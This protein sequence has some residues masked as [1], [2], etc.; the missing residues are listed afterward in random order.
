MSRC[1]P[2]YR[3]FCKVFDRCSGK[4]YLPNRLRLQGQKCG[5][6]C[7]FPCFS[8]LYLRKKTL[9]NRFF[10]VFYYAVQVSRFCKN[11]DGRLCTGTQSDDLVYSITG[12]FLICNRIN[13]Y[14]I[15]NL[16]HHSYPAILSLRF[17]LSG[18]PLTHAY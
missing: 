14:T 6:M 9:K 3:V 16:A 11:C 2:V 1:K 10:K 12:H 8:A 13:C 5:K 15:G 18:T 7:I 17:S 4:M